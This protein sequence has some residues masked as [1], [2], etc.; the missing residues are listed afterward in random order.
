VLWQQWDAWYE[1]ATAATAN[2]AATPTA[3]AILE[4][5]VLPHTEWTINEN[6]EP[7]GYIPCRQRGYQQLHVLG[8][9]CADPGVS[10]GMGENVL[11]DKW[12]SCDQRRRTIVVL[13]GC[14]YGF[15]KCV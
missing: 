13:L 9:I 4:Y 10:I 2:T 5:A 1:A 14:V 15:P 7:Y 11:C 8:R 12:S 3:A 6:H